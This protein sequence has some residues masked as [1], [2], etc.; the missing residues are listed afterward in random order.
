[1]NAFDIAIIIH[2]FI[3]T[4]FSV[5]YLLWQFDRL[6]ISENVIKTT[7]NFLNYIETVILILTIFLD[8]GTWGTFGLGAWYV[9]NS[10]LL[11]LQF[12]LAEWGWLQKVKDVF[13]LLFYAYLFLLHVL[14]IDAIAEISKRYG[15]S[16]LAFGASLRGNLWGDILKA[17]IIATIKLAFSFLSRKIDE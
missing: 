17:I 15:A 2:L 16:V 8:Y 5:F 9:L 14:H 6:S 10:I 13:W 11:I 4:I 7:I 12:S 3:E 1:M